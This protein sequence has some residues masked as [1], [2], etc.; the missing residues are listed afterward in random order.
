MCSAGV[1]EGTVGGTGHTQLGAEE[2]NQDRQ[3]TSSAEHG[4]RPGR[5][6]LLR[7][8]GKG[9]PRAGEEQGELQL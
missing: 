8:R 1:L 5:V 4:T 6:P 9:Q 2:S 7:R 3:H